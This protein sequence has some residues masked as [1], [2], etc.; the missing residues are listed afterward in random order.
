METRSMKLQRKRSYLALVPALALVFA[1]AS[2][3]AGDA[4]KRATPA[5]H[6]TV[7]TTK[8]ASTNVQ[9]MRASDLIGKNVTNPKG[10]GL[11][12]IKDLVVDTTNGRVQYAVISM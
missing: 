8:S 6:P 2:N 10:D 7:A 12:E 9:Q 5:A 4:D 1:T 11:G 3:A